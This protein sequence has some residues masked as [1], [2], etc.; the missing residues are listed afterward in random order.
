MPDRVSRKTGR[1]PR[2]G[3]L[4]FCRLCTDQRAVPLASAHTTGPAL[5]L[6]AFFARSSSHKK[7]SATASPFPAS[8]ALGC[9]M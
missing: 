2:I 7:Q 6:V 1:S 5:A 3:S 9:G 4:Y 8:D